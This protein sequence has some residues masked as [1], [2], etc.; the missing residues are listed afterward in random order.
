MG[1]NIQSGQT[2]ELKDYNIDICC[3]SAKKAALRSKSKDWLVLS[4]LYMCVCVW[5]VLSVS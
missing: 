1:L 4:Q 2:K 5:T 3:L